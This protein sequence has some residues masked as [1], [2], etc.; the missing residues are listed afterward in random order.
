[1]L[2]MPSHRL[3]MPETVTVYGTEWCADC[4]RTRRYLDATATPYRWVDVNADAEVRVMLD[5]A[6]YRSIPVVALPA[7]RSW[8]SPPRTSSPTSSAPPPDRHS[9]IAPATRAEVPARL[10]SATLPGDGRRLPSRFVET[11][12]GT[13]W[14]CCLCW[15]CARTPRL[16][17]ACRRCWPSG[18]A[19]APR[20]A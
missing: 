13:Q 15:F 16:S 18:A 12:V 2:A 19:S 11:I 14:H 10:R 7:A 20:A 8:S 1:M 17:F 5:A 4:R 3:P 9:S 6:G